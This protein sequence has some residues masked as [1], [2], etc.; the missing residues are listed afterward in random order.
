MHVICFV[1]YCLSCSHNVPSSSHAGVQYSLEADA[2]HRKKGLTSRVTFT[3]SSENS[4]ESKGTIDLTGQGTKQCVTRKISIQVPTL[5]CQLWSQEAAVVVFNVVQWCCSSGQHSRQAERNP[6]RRVCGH[7]ESQS[8]TQAE[9]GFSAATCAGRQR[10][11]YNPIR[12]AWCTILNLLP[13]LQHVTDCVSE[14][15]IL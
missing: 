13:D 1:C 10:A 8:Q 5:A 9:L 4:F 14:H 6:H 2:D 15:D 11:G 7:S 3:D 12:G